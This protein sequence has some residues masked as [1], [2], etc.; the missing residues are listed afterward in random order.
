M[1]I[2]RIAMGGGNLLFL[3]RKFSCD[4]ISRFSFKRSKTWFLKF[5]LKTSTDLIFLFPDFPDLSQIF[6]WIDHNCVLEKSFHFSNRKKKIFQFV[7]FFFL[8]LYND[9]L[10]FD[11][12]MKVSK[13]SEGSRGDYLRSRRAQNVLH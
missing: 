11:F 10:L 5:Y 7:N 6:T 8:L 4:I 13:T 2:R 9:W 1:K 3:V 12:L